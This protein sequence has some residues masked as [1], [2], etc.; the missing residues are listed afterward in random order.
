MSDVIGNIAK[1]AYDA[2]WPN[3]DC[4]EFSGEADQEERD[5][6]RKAVEAVITR[7]SKRRKPYTQDEI[8]EVC[9][10]SV[11]SHVNSDLQAFPYEELTTR[12]KEVWTKATNVIIE[13]AI[14]EGE[15]KHVYED[16]DKAAQ[17]AHTAFIT[18]MAPNSAYDSAEYERLSEVEKQA[19]R[20]AAKA[21]RDYE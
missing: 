21:A 19:W 17:C 13:A 6:W 8:N 20:A 4:P 18:S 15:Y 1:L 16:P 11:L 3:F 2:Y 5:A 14:G 7:A 12:E 10:N 9:Y